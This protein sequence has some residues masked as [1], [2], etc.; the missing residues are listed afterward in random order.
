MLQT[1]CITH[2][3]IT[4]QAHIN[5]SCTTHKKSIHHISYITHHTYYII[6]Y[7]IHTLSIGH[8]IHL[9]YITHYTSY[10]TSCSC[11]HTSPHL[12]PLCLCTCASRGMAPLLP[13]LPFHGS[14]TS[15]RHRKAARLI[16]RPAAMRRRRSGLQLQCHTPG[17][18]RNWVSRCLNGQL[19]HRVP[20]WSPNW[21]IRCLNPPVP[22]LLRSSLSASSCTAASAATP[23]R[24]SRSGS[25]C[26][27]ALATTSKRWLSLQ[28]SSRVGGA[29]A[30]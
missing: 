14:S 30:R 15:E 10:R 6:P 26:S 17:R 23:W 21:F 28:G 20:N 29:V 8:I 19:G 24:A 18:H 7:I 25:Q 2:Q 27:T 12:P 3:Y 5:T 1:S 11:T 4:H 9:P 13:L 22:P 16:W